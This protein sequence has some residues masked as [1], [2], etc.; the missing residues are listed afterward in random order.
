MSSTLKH[1]LT[2]IAFLL[3]IIVLLAACRPV[4]APAPDA[5]A[6][7]PA[8]AAGET[9]SD[10]P[11]DPDVRVGKLDNGLTYYIRANAEPPD[12]ADLWLAI[13]AGSNLEDD[14]Q[15]GLAHFLEHMLFN[16]TENFPGQELID[17]LESI[18]MRFGPDVNAYTTFDETVYTL[19]APTDDAEKLQKAF[20]VLADWSSRATISPEEVD[21]ERGVIVEEWRLRDL[22]AG[23]RVNDARDRG[24]AG[25]LALRRTSA[26]RRHGDRALGAGGNAAALL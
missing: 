12:R 23:G 17:Y 10:L 2:R 15:K 25:G 13:N 9:A 26:H 22:N 11:F 5:A 1:S 6:S 21:A 19:Q 16:G 20:D 3:L 4:Q 7:A 14:D 8:A 24:A 18:G